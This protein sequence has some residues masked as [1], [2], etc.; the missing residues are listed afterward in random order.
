MGGGEVEIFGR[1]GWGGGHIL[2]I[3]L[4]LPSYCLIPTLSQKIAMQCTTWDVEENLE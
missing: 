3:F 2:N 4:I 1:W